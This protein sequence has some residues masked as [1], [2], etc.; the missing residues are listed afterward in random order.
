MPSR[1]AVK[2]NIRQID[3]MIERVTV[4]ESSEA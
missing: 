3:D 2:D 4:T 1:N